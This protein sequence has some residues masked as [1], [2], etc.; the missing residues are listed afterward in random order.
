MTPEERAAIKAHV[1]GLFPEPDGP[2]GLKLYS[3]EDMIIAIEETLDAVEV[4][5]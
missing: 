1:L 5:P 3:R 2:G 4:L